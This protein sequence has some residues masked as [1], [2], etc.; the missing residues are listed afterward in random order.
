M[1]FRS[2]L[3]FVGCLFGGL[4]GVLYW[5]STTCLSGDCE[6]GTNLF[7]IVLYGVFIGLFFADF[8]SQG[9]TRKEA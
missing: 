8:L 5:Y 9:M 2:L 3:M 6:T 1:K 4:G 7:S